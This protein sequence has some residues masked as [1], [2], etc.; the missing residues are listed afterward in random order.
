MCSSDLNGIA[1]MIERCCA[2]AHAIATGI[3]SLKGAELVWEPLINQ[4][5]VRFPDRRPG[6]SDADHDRNTEEVIAKIVATGEAFFGPT[7]WE[8][9]RCMRISVCNWQTSERDVER[10]IAAAAKVLGA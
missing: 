7:T 2:R 1:D 3:G 6:A 5:L 4:G 10:A 8:G 9:K